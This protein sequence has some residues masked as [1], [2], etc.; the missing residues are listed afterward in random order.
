[1]TNQEQAD[2]SYSK[3]LHPLMY[4][5]KKIMR[6]SINRSSPSF[7][8]PSLLSP[9]LTRSDGLQWDVHIAEGDVG[10]SG[11]AALQGGVAGGQRAEQRA[12][13]G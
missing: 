8:A 9:V 10:G 4:L 1:M 7:L 6:H 3:N 11:G 2:M 12:A 13:R 5:K